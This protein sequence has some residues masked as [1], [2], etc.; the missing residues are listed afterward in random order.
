M[1]FLEWRDRRCGT[2]GHPRYKHKL[3]HRFKE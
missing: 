1:G 3:R 2:C